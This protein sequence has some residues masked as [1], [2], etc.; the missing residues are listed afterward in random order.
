MDRSLDIT[1]KHFEPSI[2]VGYPTI[3]HVSNIKEMIPMLWNQ[4]RASAEQITKKKMPI[5]CIG[6]EFYPFDIKNTGYF[7]YMPSFIVNDLSVIPANMCAKTIAGGLH[8]V[9]THKGSTETL[10]STFDYIYQ[11]WMPNNKEYEQSSNYDFEWYDE[12]FKRL[13]PSSELEIWVPVKMK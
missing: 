7:Y 5:Q 6:L 9:F 12:R 3:L 13:D 2:L 11:E 4:L 1:F 10:G 8:A